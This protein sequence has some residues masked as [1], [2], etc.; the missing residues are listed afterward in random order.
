MV[1][2]N[3]NAEKALDSSWRAIARWETEGGAPKEGYPSQ[4][5]RERDGREDV[6][7]CDANRRLTS[8]RRAMGRLMM[9]KAEMP[10]TTARAGNPVAGS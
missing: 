9:T 8:A 4:R 5:V 6:R 10:R 2:D 3:V 7:S 1:G